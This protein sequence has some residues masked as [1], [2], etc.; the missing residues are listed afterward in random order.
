MNDFFEE[1]E[2]EEAEEEETT[3]PLAME[4]FEH[5]KRV[6]ELMRWSY[7]KDF[8]FCF[9]SRRDIDDLAYSWLNKEN[10]KHLHH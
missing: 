6:I 9:N 4:R 2:I 10:Q 8:K 3:R 1:N 7:P 5:H